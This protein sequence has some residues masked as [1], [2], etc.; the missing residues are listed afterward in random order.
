MKLAEYARANYQGKVIAITG[1]VG[2]TTTKDMVHHVL[3]HAGLCFKSSRTSNA[4]GGICEAVI[5]RPLSSKFT[6][7]EVG[8]MQAGHMQTARLARP[9]VGVVTNVGVSHLQNYS[10]PDDILREKISL[11]DQLEGE[12][13]GV[14]HRSVLDADA[15]RARLIPSKKLARLVT[16]GDQPD[17]DVFVTEATFDGAATEGT[18]SVFGTA[19]RFRLPLPARHFVENAML[20]IGVASILDLD[21]DPLIASLATVAPTP[22][23]FMRYRV[24]TAHG[25]LELIDDS[26]NAA[27]DS[28]TALLDTLK[29][30]AARRKVFVFGD[31]LELGGETQRF[32]QELAPEIRRAGIDLV[33]TVGTFARLA[34]EGADAM[35][36]AD[37]QSASAAVVSLLRPGDLVAVKASRR[38]G[39]DKVVAA[40]QFAGDSTPAGSWRIE[41]DI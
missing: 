27:P 31:M 3:S 15:A 10:H 32:H 13:L 8:A 38:I 24:A 23:R 30:R 36:Y 37:A 28:V 19:Y 41:D 5:N 14:V 39:L 34:A 18:M 6:V 17:N 11:F 33:V 22:R 9:H 2:K 25:M 1:S 29:Q 35:N 40:I 12:R 7:V 16:V 4:V 21:L 26:Y 20:A